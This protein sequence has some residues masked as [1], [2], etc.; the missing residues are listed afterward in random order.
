MPGG[1]NSPLTFSMFAPKQMSELCRNVMRRP[2]ISVRFDSKAW[3]AF[4]IMAQKGIS[5]IAVVDEDGVIIHNTST[6]DL[7]AL[8]VAN[9]IDNLSLD[10]TIEDF[11]VRLRSLSASASTRVP[12][13]VN[14]KDDEVRVIVAKLHRTGYHR[15]WII[16]SKRKPSGLVSLADLFRHLVMASDTP[17]AA[18]AIA[19]NKAS[20][21]GNC[22]LQ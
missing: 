13:S 15:V 21:G 12:V 7:K 6:S 18:K 19:S 14:K 9:N 22:S 17:L 11:L 3:K 5:G 2:V 1:W 10:L 16:N 4:D 20:G 8:I